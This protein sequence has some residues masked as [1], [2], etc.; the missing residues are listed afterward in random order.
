MDERADLKTTDN[1]RY[2]KME[3]TKV[4]D[5]ISNYLEKTDKNQSFRAI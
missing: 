5:L 2:P 1:D 4:T 3:W